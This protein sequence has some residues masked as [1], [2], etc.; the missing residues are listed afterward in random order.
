MTNLKRLG[1]GKRSRTLDS[2]IGK[3]SY[4]ILANISFNYLEE[5][6]SFAVIL[7]PQLFCIY[8]II[9]LIE[10]YFITSLEI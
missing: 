6:I 7:L 2:K 4:H 1:R 8:G 10:C 5:I 9:I 3:I